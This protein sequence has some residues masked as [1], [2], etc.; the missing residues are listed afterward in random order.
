MAAKLAL[1]TVQFGLDYGV[2][3]TAG[4]INEAM[5]GTILS[6]AKSYGINMLDTAALYG[7]SEAVLGQQDLSGF[8]IVTKTPRFATEQI[9][10]GQA[11]VLAQTFQQ[12][13]KKLQQQS[14]YG[15]LAHHVD[16]LLAPGGETLWSAMQNL[17]ESGAVARIGASVYEGHQIDALLERFTPDLIQLPVNILDQRLVKTGHIEKLKAL[18]VEVHARSAFLQGLLLMSPEKVSAYFD[19]ICHQLR[20]CKDAATAQG[21]TPLQAALAYVRDLPGVDQVV[22]GVTSVEE[23]RQCAEAFAQAEHFSGEGLACDESAF[24]NPALWRLT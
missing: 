11:E 15:L 6:K 3:N 21:M 18:G 5:V 13:R 1:G 19:P 24:V 12:S 14:L 17:K 8:N 9:A 2:S 10:E 23:L 16:D 7:E 4:Q 20:Q 22:V